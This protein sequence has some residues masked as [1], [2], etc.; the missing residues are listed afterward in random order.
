VKT[1][2][3]KREEAIWRLCDKAAA[4]LP[5]SIPEQMADQRT[6]AQKQED[7]RYAIVAVRGFV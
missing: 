3:E 4:F 5:M 7:L 6:H 2:S 1:D